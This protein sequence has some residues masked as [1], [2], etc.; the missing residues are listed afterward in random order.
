MVASIPQ[1]TPDHL[2][3]VELNVTTDQTHVDSGQLTVSRGGVREDVNNRVNTLKSV[4]VSRPHKALEWRYVSVMLYKF[5][6]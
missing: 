4:T 3:R 5:S 6:S 1:R 2:S